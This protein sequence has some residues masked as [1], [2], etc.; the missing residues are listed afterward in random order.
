MHRRKVLLTKVSEELSI[1][2]I[3]FRD[4]SQQAVARVELLYFLK[5]R[6]TQWELLR[7]RVKKRRLA[8]LELA[9]L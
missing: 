3:V 8:L 4:L 1:R 2:S 7:L 9:G 6:Q 5:D